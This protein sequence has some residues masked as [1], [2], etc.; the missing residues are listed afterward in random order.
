MPLTTGDDLRTLLFAGLDVAH[1]PVALSL[2]DHGALVRVLVEGVSD[3]ERLGLL[4]EAGGELVVDAL[5]DEDSGSS[6]TRLTAVEA[7][8]SNGGW[9]MRNRKLYAS[10]TTRVTPDGVG[11]ADEKVEL[12]LQDTLRSVL[13]GVVEVRIVEDDVGTL[14]TELERDLL[15]VGL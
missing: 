12:H 8:V 5:L 1:N 3:L 7:G 4:L 10:E 13:D 15:Q 14:T 2:R 11:R 9:K 6:A